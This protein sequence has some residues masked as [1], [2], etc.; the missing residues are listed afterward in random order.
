MKCKK[1]RKTIP[2]GSKFCNHCG[3][4][5]GGKKKLYRRP[6]GLY[7][8]IMMIDGKRVAFRAKK[9]ADV[10]KKIREYESTRTHEEE[11]G[12]LFTEI[13][14]EWEEEHRRNISPT[15]WNQCYAYP[16]NEIKE[17]FTNE[18]IKDITH[19]DINAYMKKLPK[20]YARKTCANRLSILNMIFKY[21]VV[22]EYIS[23]N[24]C[25]Y[26]SVPKGHGASK[27]RAPDSGEMEAIKANY[28]V[29]YKNVCV[30]FLA[31]FLLYTGLRKGEALA[32]TFGD[33]DR[34]QKLISVTKSVY[35]ESNEPHIKNP[36]TAAGVREVVIP[37]YLLP[38]IPKGK[39]GDLVFC[40]YA[41]ELMKKDFFDKAWHHWQE[42]TG[43]DLTAHQL[44]HGYATLLHD[45]D[46]D[47][48]DAQD[49]LGHADAST[50]QNIYT[51]VSNHR[52]NKIAERLNSYLQ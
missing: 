14:E 49:Q 3:A 36:K 20:T 15:S 5:L 19:K 34:D 50:T 43:L 18:F 32:L 13:A 12:A 42:E 48:K 11:H 1:C 31:L 2:D 45:A 30:G 44:R 24:P 41:G 38:L 51:E 17:Y 21:A 29:T 27:R 16:F 46:V 6:D 28:M 23:E 52:R 22:E 47:V 25:S 33:I 10:F 37:D 35:Y 7:E 8:K 40:R 26:I 4:P 9:E 39:M